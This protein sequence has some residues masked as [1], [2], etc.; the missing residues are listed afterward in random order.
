MGYYAA[1]DPGIFDFFEN[2]AKNIFSSGARSM[3]GEWHAN[4]GQLSLSRVIK[5]YIKPIASV[6]PGLGAIGAAAEYAYDAIDDPV[7]TVGS[8]LGFAPDAENDYD[9]MATFSGMDSDTAVYDPAP[10]ST[11]YPGSWPSPEMPDLTNAAQ[12]AA[13]EWNVSPAVAIRRASKF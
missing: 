1:G 3:G 9:D 4:P 8:A 10:M 5:S 2:T 7:R 6:V 12:A 13:Q 11:G